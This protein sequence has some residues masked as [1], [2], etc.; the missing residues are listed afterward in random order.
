VG[1]TGPVSREHRFN[2][3]RTALAPWA[4]WPRASRMAGTDRWRSTREI[5][6]TSST[7]NA[8]RVN[9][10]RFEVVEQER[11]DAARRLAGVRL[12][13]P[14]NMRWSTYCLNSVILKSAL[15]W[16]RFLILP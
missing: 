2:A 16:A 7:A 8:V 1:P 3:G 11:L 6:S 10:G 12:R 4:H 13:N 5:L 9:D 14:R 15:A